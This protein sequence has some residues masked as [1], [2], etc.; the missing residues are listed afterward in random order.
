MSRFDGSLARSLDFGETTTT[1]G[2][3]HS[4]GRAG[5]RLASPGGI[6]RGPGKYKVLESRRR[7]AQIKARRVLDLIEEMERTTEGV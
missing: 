3:V 2:P 6:L 1:A 5:L 4:P 7:L